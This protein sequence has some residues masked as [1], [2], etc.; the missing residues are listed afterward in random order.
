MKIGILQTGKSHKSLLDKFGDYPDLFKTFLGSDNF[1]FETYPVLEMVFPKSSDECD[2]WLITGSR[3]GVYEDH[4]WLPPLREFIKRIYENKTPLVGICFGHQIIAQALGGVVEKF[5]GGWSVGATK[6]KFE[7]KDVT[8]NAWHQDQVIVPPENAKTV[9]T[10]EFCKFAGLNYDEKIITF[11]PHP[12]FNSN[13]VDG[14]I[15]NRGRGIV[16]G[17]LL[18]AA[19]SK[20]DRSNDNDLLATKILAF[21]VK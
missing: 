19:K 2:G 3:H 9:M 7:D 21:F 5:K 14:L 18:V 16:P 4:E 13:Y 15:E 12:E 6:Y 10:N 17:S 8:L 11:Q 20:L 1:V